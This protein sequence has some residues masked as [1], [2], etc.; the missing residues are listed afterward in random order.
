M[1]LAAFQL[2]RLKQATSKNFCTFPVGV[3]GKGSVWITIVRAFLS[4]QDARDRRLRCSRLSA[5]RLR[6][7][8]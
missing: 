7:E 2:A 8:M 6:L 5:D 3:R 1:S 4:Q